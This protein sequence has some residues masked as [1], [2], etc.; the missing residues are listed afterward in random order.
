MENPIEMDDLGVLLFLET[1]ILSQMVV[2]LMVM[3][4]MGSQSAK[5]HQVNKSK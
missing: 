4:P 3:N 5:N 2:S 1:P